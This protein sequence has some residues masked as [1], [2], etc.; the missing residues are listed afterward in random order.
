MKLLG[1]LD[2]VHTAEGEFPAFHRKI[3]NEVVCGSDWNTFQIISKLFISNS[4]SYWVSNVFTAAKF[5]VMLFLCVHKRE[6][7]LH[8]ISLFLFEFKTTEGDWKFI[9][10]LAFI[11]RK[12]FLD[13]VG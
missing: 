10:I 13:E 3:E 11:S 6:T 1:T 8:R 5:T 9:L 2:T 4:F 12:C 7:G